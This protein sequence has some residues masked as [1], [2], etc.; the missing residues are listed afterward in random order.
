VS[1]ATDA[2]SLPAPKFWNPEEGQW[3]TIRRP[4]P[5][6]EVPNPAP[7]PRPMWRM[8]VAEIQDLTP[9]MRR[10]R[11]SG[12]TLGAF[13]HVPGADFT[14][15]LP[16]DNGETARRHY[17]ARSYDA[18]AGLL[19]VD[20]VLHGEGPAM[21]WVEGVRVGDE[22]DV[23]GPVLRRNP[24]DG[25]DWRLYAGDETAIPAID[26]MI[27]ALPAG[28]RA[29]VFLEV[30]DESARPPVAT[31][32]DVSET[33]LV[34]GRTPGEESTLLRDALAA[35]ALPEGNGDVFLAGETGRMREIRQALLAR[36]VQREQIFAMGYWR[37]G[38]FGGDEVV[39]D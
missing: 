21:K 19:D 33:L 3:V 18:A 29:F 34:R 6:A 12:A 7:P 30:P 15:F 22:V 14:L 17:T 4:A 24:L 36:G 2:L 23:T 27:E 5:T 13:Q 25:V 31:Q 1:N 37:P 39:R 26:G 10:L 20:F 8:K 38:R 16:G 11:F 32:A 35:F 28:S 9:Q